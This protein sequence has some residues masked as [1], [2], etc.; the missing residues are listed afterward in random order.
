MDRAG[1]SLIEP[2]RKGKGV[3]LVLAPASLT[4]YIK[5]GGMTVPTLHSFILLFPSFI[6]I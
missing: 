2:L 3:C 6:E 4:L 5:K 1:L